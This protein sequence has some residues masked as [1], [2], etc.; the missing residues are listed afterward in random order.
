MNANEILTFHQDYKPL[1]R[2]GTVIPGYFVSKTGE[3]YSEKTNRFL[4]SHI[5]TVPKV[6]GTRRVKEVLYSLSIERGLIEGYNHTRKDRVNCAKLLVPAHRAVAESWT[7]I[8]EYPPEE[9]ANTWNDVPEEWRQ[10]VRDTALV[11][12]KDDDPT[13][14]SKD[15]LQWKTPLQN[16]PYRKKQYQRELENE[17]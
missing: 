12:H 14:N 4:S 9:L 17:V 11:D 6:D 1:V 13:N 7:P 5:H 10:W 3:I 2:F 16:Q 15:N 8:D